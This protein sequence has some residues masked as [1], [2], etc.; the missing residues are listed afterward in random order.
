MKVKNMNNIKLGK[1]KK[2][3]FN[4]VNVK[5]IEPILGNTMRNLKIIF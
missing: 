1:K 2:I 4:Y 3:E 5:A